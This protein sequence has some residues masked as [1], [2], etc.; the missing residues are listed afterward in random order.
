MASY[1]PIPSFDES[2]KASFWAKVQKSDGCW[3]WTSSLQ[4]SGY[5]VFH[6]ARR[7]YRAHRVAFEMVRGPIPAGLVLDHRCHNRACVNPDHLVPVTAEMNRQLVAPVGA[8]HRVPLGHCVQCHVKSETYR[9]ER[10]R[11]NHNAKD[12]PSQRRA[13]RKNH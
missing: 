11:K 1:K 5:G 10:C 12:K 8:R 2:T 13:T 4:M 7:T 6:R 3:M 9:C